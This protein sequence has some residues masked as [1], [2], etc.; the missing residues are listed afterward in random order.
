MRRPVVVQHRCEL[1]QLV[2]AKPFSLD[3][4]H[5]GDDIFAVGAGLTV[6]LLHV[7]ELLGQ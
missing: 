1:M 6:S 3:R 7:A 5:G 4:L 2:V